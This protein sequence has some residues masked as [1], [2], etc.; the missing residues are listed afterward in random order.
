MSV[1][2]DVANK[3]EEDAL[4]LIE[5]Y[6]APVPLNQHAHPVDAI[7]VAQ[8]HATLAVANAM[9]AVAAELDWANTNRKG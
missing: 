7:A 2:V 4:V 5:K 8:V 9:L 1:H 3:H 6:L